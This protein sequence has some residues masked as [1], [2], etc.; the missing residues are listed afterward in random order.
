MLTPE[1]IQR[2]LIQA[3]EDG[4]F[5]LLLLELSTGLRRGEICALQ[6]NDLNFR[7]GELRVERQV[8]RVK[9][10][11][12]VS[13]PKTKASNR[14]VILPAPV[15]GVLRAYRETIN[16]KWMFPSPANEASPRDPAAVRKRLQTVLER[17][18][19]KKIRFHDLRHTFSTVSLEHGMDVK[20]LSTIIGHVSS[21]TTLNVY[22]HV[23][24][25]MR[26]TAAVKIDQGIGKAD[27][28]AATGTA[29]RKP[30][31]STFQS[32]KGQRRK[33]GTG[34]VTQINEKLWEGRYS[35]IWPDGKKHARNVYAHSEEE[36]EKLLAEMITEMKAEIA[37]EKKR[38]K[39]APKAG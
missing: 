9:G 36:C 33:A 38:L 18:G 30:A 28:Q 32:Y 22:A 4:C 24:D 19:C 26:R 29:P 37:T 3:K 10:E 35:P 6:W 2:L 15:L 34:C 7:I 25:E 27:P 20:T 16:S 39:A 12:V 5:E 17:A 23:T 11:L 1:E 21:S 14:S 13:P 8:H 31:P